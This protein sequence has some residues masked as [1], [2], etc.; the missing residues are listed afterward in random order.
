MKKY[1]IRLDDAC[2]KMDISKWNRIEDIF[3]KYNVKPLVGII[4]CCEDPLMG[5]YKFNNSFWELVR[6]WVDKGWIM[7][8]HGCNH[9]YSTNC[10]YA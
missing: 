2:E 6:R 8:L 1:L 5:A 7:A 10:S 3:D 9:V 4:P